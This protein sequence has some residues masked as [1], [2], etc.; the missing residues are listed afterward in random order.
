MVN[1]TSRYVTTGKLYYSK[2]L[3]KKLTIHTGVYTLPYTN[4]FSVIFLISHI[5]TIVF[6]GGNGGDGPP[7]PAGEDGNDVSLE[8]NTSNRRLVHHARVLQYPSCERESSLL[9]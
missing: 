2:H 6:Q 4:F 8:Y 9:Y 5:A 7:G 1:C 3:E